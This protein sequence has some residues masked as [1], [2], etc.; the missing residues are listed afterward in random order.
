MIVL[1]LIL[2]LLSVDDF[3]QSQILGF[4]V[5]VALSSAGTF[6]SIS[7]LLSFYFENQSKRRMFEEVFEKTVGSTSVF[8]AGIIQCIDNS[9]DIVYANDF[10]NT[11]SVKAVFSY[12]ADFLKKY[13]QEIDELAKSG[14]AIDFVFLKEDGTVIGAMKQ[15]GWPEKSISSNMEAIR[16]AEKKF[17]NFDNVTFHYVDAIPRYS[18]V[19][20][21]ACAYVIE[22]TFSKGRTN[23]PATKLDR[24]GDM[25]KFYEADIERLLNGQ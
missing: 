11:Q 21:D 12:S 14:G 25:A 18:L 20:F 10:K 22:N 24:Q 4:S 17:E 1:G 6:L 7:A 19:M 13:S 3:F 8:R 23:V 9:R 16:S 2:V 15:L 5:P